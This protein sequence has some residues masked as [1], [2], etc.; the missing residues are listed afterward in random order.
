MLRGFWDVLSAPRLVRRRVVGPP[1]LAEHL[2]VVD[3]GAPPVL[4]GPGGVLALPPGLLALAFP[5][6]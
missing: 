3:I 4:V 5:L 1:P 2:D 6:P